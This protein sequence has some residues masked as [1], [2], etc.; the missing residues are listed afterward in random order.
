MVDLE[1]SLARL[2]VLQDEAGNNKGA[3]PTAGSLTYKILND[4]IIAITDLREQVTDLE[5]RIRNLEPQNSV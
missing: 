2:R 4:V 5:T 3:A 1:G